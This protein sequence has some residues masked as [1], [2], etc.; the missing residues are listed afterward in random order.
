[1]FDLSQHLTKWCYYAIKTI[2]AHCLDGNALYDVSRAT[3]VAQL[4]YAWWGFLKADEKSRLQ[5][6]VK[7]S[8]VWVHPPFKTLDELRQGLDETLFHSSRYYPHH[9]IYRLLPRPKDTGHKLLQR[10]H[11]PTLS[12][13]VGSTAKQAQPRLKSWGGPR[14]VSQ[15]RGASA[16][17]GP[18]AGGGCWVREGV[19]PS[20]CEG[21]GYQ[22]LKIFA[23]SDAKSCILVTTVL[24]SGLPSTWNFLLF[25]NYG[26]EVGGTNTLLVPQPKSWGA[27]S[28]G[29]Y[30]CCAYAS[31][32]LFLELN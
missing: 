27:V 26:Q 7:N 4:L 8:T 15:H 19:A 29:P 16:R 14:F 13:D 32:I 9:V 10:A 25:E 20:R 30:G 24:I 12:S 6:V 1:L 22:P 17:A 5:A 3:V 11:N 21:W 18:K 23:N 28:P 2:R 31:R